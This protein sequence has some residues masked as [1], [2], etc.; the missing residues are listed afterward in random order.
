VVTPAD[1]HDER[2]AICLEAGV[3]ADRAAAIARCEGYAATHRAAGRIARCT[4]GAHR[5]RS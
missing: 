2:L 1:V 5:V 4:C 3:P